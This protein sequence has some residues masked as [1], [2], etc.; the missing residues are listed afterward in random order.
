MEVRTTILGYLQRGG[1]PTAHDRILAT[2]LGVA[3]AQWALQGRSGIM[4]ALRGNEIKPVLF[5]KVIQKLKQVDPKIYEV[6]ASFF[7]A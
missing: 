6:A 7:D 5:S 1:I 4:A 3:A 2:R